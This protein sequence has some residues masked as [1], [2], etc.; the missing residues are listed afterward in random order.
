M[1]PTLINSLQELAQEVHAEIKIINSRNDLQCVPDTTELIEIL[2]KKFGIIPFAVP[3]LLKILV[4]SS[5]LFSFSLVEEDRKNKIRKIEGHIISDG[6]L[7]QIIKKNFEQ[8]LAAL[9]TKEFTRKYTPETAVKEYIPQAA[10]FNNTEIGRV[11][12]TAVMA[13]HYEI[14]FNRKI[15]SYSV[16]S[17]L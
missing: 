6:P 10:K 13:A 2:T 12:N 7:L 3:K 1:S 14:I 11:G 8:K 16:M 5:M 4:E 9:F 17:S 15:L